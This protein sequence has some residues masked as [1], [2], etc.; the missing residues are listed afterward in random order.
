MDVACRE[1]APGLV[2]LTYR[3]IQGDRLT[4][5]SS[6]SRRVDDGWQVVVTRARSCSREPAQVEFVACRRRSRWGSTV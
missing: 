3:L 6:L 5:R 2:Q 4:W 1:L